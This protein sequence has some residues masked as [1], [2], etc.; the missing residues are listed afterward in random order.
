MILAYTNRGR[1]YF[2]LEDYIA[3]ASDFNQ[4][5]ALNPKYALAYNNRGTTH[6]KK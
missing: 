4:A 3:A 6:H 1:L 2:E 5:I